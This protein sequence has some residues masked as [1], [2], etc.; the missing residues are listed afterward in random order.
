M[1]SPILPLSGE[2]SGILSGSTPAR[3]PTASANRSG[4]HTAF[5]SRTHGRGFR[6][7]DAGCGLSVAKI[8]KGTDNHTGLHAKIAGP[9]L[10]SAKIVKTAGRKRESARSFP[11][12][13]LFSAKI[14]KGD[15]NH[16]GCTQRLPDRILFLCKDS[17]RQ[18]SGQSLASGFS[19]SAGPGA[20]APVIRSA[21]G[22]RQLSGRYFPWRYGRNAY[23]RKYRFSGRSG[24]LAEGTV[25]GGIFRDAAPSGSPPASGRLQNNIINIG[26]RYDGRL[27]RAII[28]DFIR[29]HNKF[30]LKNDEVLSVL[31]ILHRISRIIENKNL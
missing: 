8:T 31:F 27:L 7:R 16:T 30:L 3:F 18:V 17:E 28:T 14:A 23:N 24:G 5:P 4:R 19:A 21:D 26:C 2:G 22:F 6:V 9:S 20:S 13:I 1:P 10:S 29:R 25:Y 15:G 12:R 11:R